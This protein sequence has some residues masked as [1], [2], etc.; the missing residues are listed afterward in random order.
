MEGAQLNYKH[1][2]VQN[3]P[4]RQEG[5]KKNKV[6]RLLRGVRQEH[7]EKRGVKKTI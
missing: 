2:A 1:I 4:P 6:K 7:A 5:A 3:K